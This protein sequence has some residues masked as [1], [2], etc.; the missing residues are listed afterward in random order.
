MA[1]DVVNNQTTGTKEFTAWNPTP[2]AVCNFY[3]RWPHQRATTPRH[4]CALRH[5]RY[6]QSDGFRPDH[7]IWPNSAGS[8]SSGPFSREQLMLMEYNQNGY[9]MLE[10]FYSKDEVK[11][12]LKIIHNI[13]EKYNQILGQ[14]RDITV[15]ETSR[16]VTEDGGRKI[17]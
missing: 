11:E 17:K 14:D 5:A 10:G 6:D 12:M 8:W 1:T 13:R 16:M 4:A 7:V 3:I 9:L 2:M 15:T